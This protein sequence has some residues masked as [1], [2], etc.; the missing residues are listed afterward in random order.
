TY[1]TQ[2]LRSLLAEVFGRISGTKPASKPIIR[3][4]TS[5]GGGKTHNLIA[6]YH[7]A[8]GHAAI[9]VDKGLIDAALVPK[10]PIRVA[11]VVGSE[12]DP[13]NPHIR[14]KSQTRTPWG[15]MAYQLA[16]EEAAAKI[17]QP[18]APGK[19]T[20]E[21]LIGDEPTLVM[22]DEMAWYLRVARGHEQG[23]LARQ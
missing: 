18:T 16:G 19:G 11:G 6:C 17:E 21:D 7:V 15:E 14:G 9:A 3:L 8:R 13:A 5:F 22:L 12:L 2:G 1:P 23:E 20:L 4:E 10:T